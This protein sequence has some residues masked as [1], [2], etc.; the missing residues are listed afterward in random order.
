[1]LP[2]TRAIQV[3]DTY[4]LIPGCKKRFSTDC[5]AKFNNGVNF[6]GEPHVPGLDAVIK[7]PS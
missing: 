4:S 1:M 5:V 6:R 2:M 7:R 3:G